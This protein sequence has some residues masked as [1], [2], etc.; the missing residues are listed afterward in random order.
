MHKTMK[1]AYCNGSSECGIYQYANGNVLRRLG[2]F[3]H[4]LFN[5]EHDIALIKL[6]K[7]LKCKDAVIFFEINR[8]KG[9][10]ASER[11]V[12]E[13]FKKRNVNGSVP[14]V[15]F[16]AATKETKGELFAVDGSYRRKHG[17]I[18]DVHYKIRMKDGKVFAL[19]G[20]S[21]ALV[22]MIGKGGEKMP[23]AYLIRK[24]SKNDFYC[25]NLKSGFKKLSSSIKPCLRECGFNNM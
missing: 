20:D 23:F 22:C 2:T 13:E 11:K 15:K 25:A 17:R 7:D 10:F 1:K 9:A 3:D 21:G 16:G 18:N 14:V 8:V 12:I 19:K 4:G 5:D 24:S 6:D